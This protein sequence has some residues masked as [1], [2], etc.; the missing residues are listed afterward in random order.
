MNSWQFIDIIKWI[1]DID[2]S[3]LI[4]GVYKRITDIDKWITDI[5]NS[6]IDIDK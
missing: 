6:I 2:K 5:D 4:I 3:G 1:S